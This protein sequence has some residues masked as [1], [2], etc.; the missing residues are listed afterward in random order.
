MPVRFIQ[1]PEPVRFVNPD[2]EEP[3]IGEDGSSL[4]FTMKDLLGRLNEN[5]RWGSSYSGLRA[6]DA[7]R[8]AFKKA[9]SEGINHFCV[10][11][12]DWIFL[13]GTV[14]S[15]IC[16]VNDVP[17]QGFRINPLLVVQI[18]PLLDAIVRASDS[19]PAATTKE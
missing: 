5:P 3:L 7:I 6:Q 19:P 16:M 4:Q 9:M 17:T 14:E 8:K 2:T 13:K 10:S 15:P 1:I 12:E 11:E 18:L